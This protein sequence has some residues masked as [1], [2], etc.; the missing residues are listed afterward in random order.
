MFE[1]YIYINTNEYRL[2]IKQ[3]SGTLQINDLTVNGKCREQLCKRLDL[4]ISDVFKV[5]NKYNMEMAKS[6]CAKKEKSP[7]KPPKKEKKP[8][9]K[10]LA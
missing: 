8:D 7:P 5:L 1:K 10:G 4:T 3:V 2:S 9:V 6:T